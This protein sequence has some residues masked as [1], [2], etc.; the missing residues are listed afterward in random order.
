MR[1]RRLGVV[2]MTMLVIT[3]MIPVATPAQADELPDAYTQIVNHQIGIPIQPDGAS[4]GPVGCSPSRSARRRRAPW[5]LFWPGL[6]SCSTTACSG[7][8]TRP[9]RR[10][11]GAV[12]GGAVA[13]RQAPPRAWLVVRGAGPGPAGHRPAADGAGRSS[14]TAC[15]PMGGWC[16]RST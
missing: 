15:G 9:L 10:C 7:G 13:G 11:A 12:A 8:R 5:G 1:I 6:A 16:W 2:A 14:A 3:A 4:C